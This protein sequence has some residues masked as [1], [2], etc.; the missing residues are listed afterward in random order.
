MRRA[1]S[2]VAK[3]RAFV[4]PSQF[5]F[6]RHV[7]NILAENQIA[8]WLEQGGDK[9]LPNKGKKLK[10]EPHRYAANALGVGADYVHSKILADNNIKPASI[11]R[12]LDLDK[13][14]EQLQR[15]IQLDFEKVGSL[16]IQDYVQS[17]RVRER[18]G[19]AMAQLDVKAKRVNDAIVSDSL[20]FNGRSP[21]RHA[22]RFQLQ[23]RIQEALLSKK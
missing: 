7:S 21:V 6:R 14:W 16:S 12:R 2:I 15:E 11:E 9:N 10:E 8:A 3:K 23:E 20:R 5:C 22:C 4:A 1:S 13:N 17:A 18:F 19:D